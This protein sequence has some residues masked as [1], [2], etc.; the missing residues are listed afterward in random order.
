MA[1]FRGGL[2]ALFGLYG[3]LFMAFGAL[4]PYLPS[5]LAERGLRPAE[6]GLALAAGT[7]IRLVTGPLAGRVADRLG[8][9][10]L[11]LGVSAACAAAIVLLYGPAYGLWP[12]L[13]IGIL[14]AAMLAPLVPLADTLALGAAAPLPRGVPAWR[15]VDSWRVADYG[16][17]RGAGSAAFILGALL[18]GIAAG[19]L[20]TGVFIGLNAALLAVAAAMATA[21]P[22]LRPAPTAAP[23]VAIAPGADGIPALLRLP[24]FRR[25]MI[26][27]ALI[28]GSH[29]MHDSFAVIRWEAAGIAPG[30]A[31]LLWSEQVVAEIVV[32]LIVGRRVLDLIGPAGAAALAAVGGMVRWAVMAETTAASAM[33]LTEPLHGL[34]FALLHLACMRLVATAIPERLAA[35]A[36]ALYGT[37]V[38]GAATALATL[39]SGPLY[40]AF[41][42][43]G[44]WAMAALCAA[45]LPLASTL[46]LR[47]SLHSGGASL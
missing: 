6:I 11:V 16:W 22:R 34:S 33:M 15:I 21:A 25:L 9:P 39:A 37:A 13:V 24:I 5:L 2:S 30:L 44:F 36:L 35:T 41:G 28:L 8:A 27:A 12:L 46:R 31:G 7:A 14:H 42:A 1:R 23:P 10:K 32:F 4:S 45:A 17:L 40:A 43:R 38:V 26:V 3:A 20:G 29:A 19:A 18:S 47:S